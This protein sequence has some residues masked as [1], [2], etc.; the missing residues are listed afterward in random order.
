MKK[1]KEFVLRHPL[2][3]LSLALFA[4]MGL[5]SA[6]SPLVADD[7]SYSFTWGQPVVRVRSL[8]Q[9][10][11]SMAVHRQIT[12]GR[13]F[14]HGMVQLLMMGPKLL[15]NILN[16]LNAVLLCCLFGRYLRRAE[17]GRRAMLLLLGAM[18]L[19]LFMP[20]F[21]QIFLWLDGAVNYSWGISLFLLYLWPY[22]CRWMD[23]PDEAP[24]WSKA[25][26]LPLAFVAGAYSEN[27][28]L[29]TLFVALCLTVLSVRR[30]K[31]LSPLLA[32]GL[33][34]G[35]LGYLF[36]LLSPAMHGRSGG[37]DPAA[38]GANLRAMLRQSPGTLLPL[39]LLYAAALF[40][41]LRRG[42]DRRRMILSG[43]FMLAGLGSLSA[44]IFAL[45]FAPRHF[46]FTIFFTVLAILLLL[47]E[48]LQRDSRG[49]TRLAAGLVTLLFVLSFLRGSLDILV[50]YKKSRERL[51]AIRAAQAAGE[52]GVVLECYVPATKYSAPFGLLDLNA[53]PD[54]WPNGSLALYYG[55]DW[56]SGT[57]PGE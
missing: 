28:S 7:F 47:E 42:A 39:V 10:L 48:L 37:L 36:L 1:L 26:L 57:L 2:L 11:S 27:G 12:N 20:V 46:C 15:F 25:L 50:T 33:L 55:L 16:G 24:A 34:L 31:K 29:A 44:F 54:S 40:S 17:P 6:L 30:E 4:V 53:E 3:W 43:I 32:A 38:M 45:Y 18:L 8:G 35:G 51:A 14:A 49:L 5:F 56:V 9:I 22:V 41:C 21:G 19:W 13:V 52:Q 23:W